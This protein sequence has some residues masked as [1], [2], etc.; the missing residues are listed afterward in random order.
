MKLMLLCIKLPQMNRYVKYFNDSKGINLLIHDEE[1]LKKC[2]EIWDKISNLLKKGFNSEP[3]YNY[4][5]I[6]TKIKTCNNRII[7]NFQD[8]KIPKDNEYCA[9]LSVILI[10]PVVNV[11]RKY[12]SQIFLQECKYAVK[13]KKI[14]HSI[15]TELNLDESDDRC[16][17]EKSNKSDED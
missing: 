8:N 6:K 13:K 16:D 3:V 9:C 7:T 10:D 5:Y 2:N 12:D 1:L 4:K 17:N 15:Y 14:I 11:D